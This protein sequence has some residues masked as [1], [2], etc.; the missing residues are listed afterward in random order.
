VPPTAV[1]PVEA[2][3]PGPGWVFALSGDANRDGVADAVFYRP[4]AVA[5]EIQF[6]DPARAAVAVAARE[7]VVVQRSAV[8]LETLLQ[9]D[10][11][12]G[13][14]DRPLFDFV[15]RR[16]P[17]GYLLALDPALGPLFT[18]L[19]YG[20]GGID[21]GGLIGIDWNPGEGA[22]RLVAERP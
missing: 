4:A 18:L 9:I 20:A 5:P 7:I 13:W 19:P 15:G 17:A 16:S 14:A 21:S 10:L 1:I 6:D 11:G 2:D 12:G 22:F 8:G 3:A